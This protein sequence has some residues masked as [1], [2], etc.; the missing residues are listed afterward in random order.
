MSTEV[1][2][3]EQPPKRQKKKKRAMEHEQQIV[4]PAAY[5]RWRERWRRWRSGLQVRMTLS[6]VVATVLSL[7]L[8]EFVFGSF[9]WIFIQHQPFLRVLLNFVA[10]GLFW[11]LVAA[12]AGV[13]LG[14]LT[15]RGI[16]LRMRRLGD[17]TARFAEGD[18]SQ[19]VPEA[20][21]DEIGQLERQFNTMA[22][23][24][25]ESIAQQKRLV[26]QQA[27]IE[28]RARIEQEMQT[29]SYIQRSLLPKEIPALPGWQLA[30]FYQ[31]AREVGGDFYDFLLL[32]DGRLGLVIGDVSGKGVPAALV[33]AST[34]TMLR[35]VAQGNPAP[36]EVLAR[37]NEL[38]HSTIPAGL[39][40]TCFYGV[41]DPGTGCIRYANAG[42]D[43]PFRRSEGGIAELKA[44]GMPLGLLPGTRYDEHEAT[45]E[46]GDSVLFY[47]DGV[48]EA[49]NPAHAMFGL[50]RL[51]EL[52]GTHPGGTALVDD[53][54]SALTS[55]TG[56]N[57]EQEDDVTLVVLYR[58]SL[59]S[60][61][62]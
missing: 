43:W 62:G 9:T 60:D 29:A 52:L 39:F 53:L 28:E 11:A 51:K 22:Q 8:L 38:L 49:H 16:I 50:P 57:W 23:Q 3:M 18:Y 6:F 36:G 47:S 42:H 2:Q 12:P 19:R 40:V 56:S 25:V 41:L 20:A 59:N 26:E 13:L 35:A 7:L 55:F 24:L 61:G 32:N 30:P 15:T 14:L 37:V 34:C 58:S 44:T 48:V 10:S 21:S 5:P 1:G 17:A 31:P 4:E 46:P 54:R 33:M 27:R 45:V